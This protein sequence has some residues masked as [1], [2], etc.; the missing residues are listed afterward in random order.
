MKI[1]LEIK[2]QLMDDKDLRNHNEDTRQ[3]PP[4]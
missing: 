4:L 1:K 3:K 2:V